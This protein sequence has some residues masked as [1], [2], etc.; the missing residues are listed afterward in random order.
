MNIK[1]LLAFLT[2]VATAG[3]AGT[4]AQALQNPPCN[5]CGDGGEITNPDAVLHIPEIVQGD[6]TCA[7]FAIDGQNGLISETACDLL[8]SVTMYVCDCQVTSPSPLP[9]TCQFCTDG[10]TI[11]DEDDDAGVDNGFEYTMCQRL[12]KGAKT[13][14]ADSTYCEKLQMGEYFCCP[15][16]SDGRDGMSYGDYS[17][18][19]YTAYNAKAGKAKTPKGKHHK[20]KA[21]KSIRARE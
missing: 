7:E 2:T 6:K 16:N 21:G 14:S 3:G 19:Y 12:V 5:I 10:I 13:I 18:L 4:Q 20:S 15:S 11:K 1:H 8:P 17:Y 9:S